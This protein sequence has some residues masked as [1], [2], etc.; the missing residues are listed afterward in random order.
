MFKRFALLDPNGYITS[1][2][3]TE[4]EGFIEVEYDESTYLQLDFVKIIDGKAVI[5]EQKKSEVLED[6]DKPSLLEQ[7]QTGLAQASFQMMQSNKQIEELAKQ[8]AA[9]S[10]KMM[11][12][13]QNQ[14]N[15]SEVG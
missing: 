14:N 10:F 2:S 3:E 4:M 12:L 15:E 5:D 13:E 7:L 8:N 1:W 9:M 6:F 11:Q